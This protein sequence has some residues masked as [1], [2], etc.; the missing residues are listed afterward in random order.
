MEPINSQETKIKTLEARKT[1]LLLRKKLARDSNEME[2]IERMLADVENLL[3]KYQE[4]TTKR[5][6]RKADG[7]K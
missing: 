1:E 2:H 3:K 6:K 4:T 7:N 5:N